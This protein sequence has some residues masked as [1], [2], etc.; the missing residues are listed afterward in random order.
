VAGVFY[1]VALAASLLALAAGGL[2]VVA[3]R[4][5]VH[6]IAWLVVAA[7]GVA[8]FLAL[9]GYGYIAVFH[10]VVY[11]GTSVTLLAIVVMLLGCSVEPRGWR[12]GRML[13]SVFAAAALEAPLLIYSLANPAPKGTGVSLGEAARQLL[14]CWL[15]T[16]LM[17]ATVATVLI[18]AV[19]I[20]RSSTTAGE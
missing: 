4:K 2:G 16:L 19:A 18:E 8:A 9:L 5:A 20:A 3:A 17:V 12:P 11:V 1:D 13:L 7:L 14:D 15:C 6:Y 10:V